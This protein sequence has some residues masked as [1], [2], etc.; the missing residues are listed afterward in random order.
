MT[1]LWSFT[2]QGESVR[3]TVKTSHT[4]RQ[5]ERCF[6]MISAAVCHKVILFLTPNLRSYNTHHSWSCISLTLRRCAWGISN[7]SRSFRSRFIKTLFNAHDSCLVIKAKNSFDCLSLGAF[8]CQRVEHASVLLMIICS[9]CHK[10]E[11]CRTLWNCAEAS[12][13][14]T[15]MY[16]HFN[17][18]KSD[19]FLIIRLKY[20]YFSSLQDSAQARAARRPARLSD[21]SHLRR[22]L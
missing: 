17:T 22:W 6:S 11:E 7:G 12:L 10:P 3:V 21:W 18:T 2:T 16:C 13:M 20:F 1:W 15:N 9:N 19:N 8:L 14:W 4:H 5:T